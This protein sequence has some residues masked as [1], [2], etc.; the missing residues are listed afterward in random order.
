ML[1]SVIPVKGKMGLLFS[2]AVCSLLCSSFVGLA[3]GQMAAGP[4]CNE[5]PPGDH[6]G[7]VTSSCDDA[8][9]LT[10]ELLSEG[11]NTGVLGGLN[12]TNA[13]VTGRYTMFRVNEGNMSIDNWGVWR[14]GA[15]YQIFDG[16]TFVDAS[17]LSTSIEGA[18]FDAL[19]DDTSMRIHNHPGGIIE[20][21]ADGGARIELTMTAGVNS[22]MMDVDETGVEA[23][24]VGSD[25]ISSALIVRG[26]SLDRIGDRTL[27]V[28]LARGGEILVRAASSD[29]PAQESLLSALPAHILAEYWVLARDDA[30][31]YDLSAYREV[32]LTSST[33][34][35]KM[36]EWELPLPQ[37]SNGKV[38]AVHTDRISL[39][40]A[41]GV[42]NML[43]IGQDV[44]EANSLDEVLQAVDDNTTSA[45][46][47]MEQINNRVDIYLFV[48]S[49]SADGGASSGG[50]DAVEDSPLDLGSL[51]LPMALVAVII[52]AAVGTALWLRRG[53]K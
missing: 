8:E 3:Y 45:L 4:Q 28:N 29:T 51:A 32:N 37:E 47:F 17:E 50:A 43:S 10:E 42:K 46:Y 25:N 24:M 15:I 13:T 31:I 39:T 53:A 16:V 23:A 18:V 14:D 38:I 30:A 9:V 52:V 21:Q 36:G 2:L 6:F 5:F 22:T 41:G 12:Q 44:N 40:N 35:L 49:A 33:R 34:S 20:I 27:V 26:G 19:F 7:I 11:A 48:P 1:S